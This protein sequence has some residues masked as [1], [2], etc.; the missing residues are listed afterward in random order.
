VPV[1]AAADY[2]PD[3]CRRA[4]R[5]HG[6]CTPSGAIGGG[7]PSE[8][9]VAYAADGAGVRLDGLGLQAFEL[10]VLECHALDIPNII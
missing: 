8:D 6:Q 7:M 1:I 5:L 2:P 4:W 9:V 10:E 3:T